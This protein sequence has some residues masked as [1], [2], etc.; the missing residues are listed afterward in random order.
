MNDGDIK[1]LISVLEKG[2]KISE[3]D[4]VVLLTMIMQELYS[5]SNVLLLDS[6][7]V[8]VG[9]IH[10]QLDDMLYM[11]EVA[12]DNPEQKYLFMGDFVDRGYHSLNTFL[13]L[14]ARKLLYKGKYFLLRGNHESRQVSQMY[15]FYNEC[16]MLYGNAGIWTL[17]NDV[18]DLLPMA[19]IIDNEIFSVHGGLSPELPLIEQINSMNRQNELGST[20]P[21][22]DLCWSDPDTIQFWRQNQRGAGYIFGEDQTKEFLHTNGLSL[23]T[24]SHQLVM[25]GCKWYF[26]NQ[27][28]AIWSA[29]NYGYRSGNIASVMKYGFDPAEMRKLIFFDPAKN[30]IA[31]TEENKV[32]NYFA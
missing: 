4:A 25:E 22:G 29:P 23:I 7:I 12:G 9:D 19:A 18:F 16:L 30:R 6:P 28:I 24:R 26:D 17:C 3:E 2:E 14:V 11:F 20:G 32:S 5:E 21:L 27:L 1:K 15:G 31:P 10:G 13:L 8:I